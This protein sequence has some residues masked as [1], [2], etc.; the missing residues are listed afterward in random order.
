MCTTQRN[1]KTRRLMIFGNLSL[2]AALLLWNFV[3]L[4]GHSHQSWLDALC[5]LLFGLSIGANFS[6]LRCARRSR[7]QASIL[8]PQ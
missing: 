8:K 7:R 5:G 4:N 3:R 6:A 1:P 2:V